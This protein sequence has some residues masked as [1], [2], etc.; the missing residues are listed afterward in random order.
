MERLNGT[1]AAYN[2]ST[3]GGAAA[4]GALGPFGLLVL[5]DNSHSEQTPV[6]FYIAKGVDGNLKTF[7]CADLS[8]YVNGNPPE[9]IISTKIMSFLQKSLSF[10]SGVLYT[11][12][13]E[14]NLHSLELFYVG[15]C[16]MEIKNKGRGGFWIHEKLFLR[17]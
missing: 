1:D 15:K 2:C 11:L 4:R 9:K 5:A 10:S 16:S 17:L 6:Y 8:R 12:K 14:K 7:F 3:S 13:W